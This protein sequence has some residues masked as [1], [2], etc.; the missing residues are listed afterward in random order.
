MIKCVTL[1][2]VQSH[3]L[4]FKIA[5]PDQRPLDW[6]FGKSEIQEIIGISVIVFACLSGIITCNENKN[7]VVLKKS[8]IPQCRH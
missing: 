5:K 8:T 6:I 4:Q 7:L 1:V 2:D 3:N